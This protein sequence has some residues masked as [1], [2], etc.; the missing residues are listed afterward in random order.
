MKNIISE[1]EQIKP[2]SSTVVKIL[3]FSIKKEKSVEELISLIQLDTA[4]VTTLLKVSN[5]A[6]FGFRNKVETIDN[7][8]NL[9][10][11]NF[12]ISII[13]GSE[14]NDS[15]N[16]NFK[17][18][19][20][21]GDAFKTI[22]LMKINL[23]NLWIGKIDK[24]IKDTLLLPTIIYNIGKYIVSKEINE[25]NNTNNFILE[26]EDLN[27]CMDDIERKYCN[28]SSK[29][30]SVLLLK[31]WNISDEII[32][33]IKDNK[34]LEILDIVCNTREQFTINSIENALTKAKI[35]NL[36][37]KILKDSIDTILER[38]ED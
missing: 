5:S 15:F 6:I 28:A 33:S 19:C 36:D 7:I 23:L 25:S 8:V 3:E 9:L 1:I 37:A 14:M 18:Y 35:Y 38:F 22:N 17:A 4:L 20:I 24:E 31:H 12:T 21:S 32:N 11:V 29:E 34:I 2:L 13:L 26:S 27:I 10:G 30:V 16:V